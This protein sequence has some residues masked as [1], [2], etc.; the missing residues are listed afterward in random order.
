[1][2]SFTEIRYAAD[3]GVCTVTLDRPQRMNAVT[4]TMIQELVQAFDRA[5]SDDGVRVVIVTGAGRA[6]CAAPISGAAGRRSIRRVAASRAPR[7]CI[8]TAAVSSRSGCSTW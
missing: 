8:G 6:F 7:T 5:D 3:D 2:T 4:P 1:V